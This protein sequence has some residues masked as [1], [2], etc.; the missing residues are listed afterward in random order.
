LNRIIRFSTFEFNY[1]EGGLPISTLFYQFIFLLTA[2]AHFNDSMKMKFSFVK[3]LIE[4]L[5][6]KKIV[7]K[8]NLLSKIKYYNLFYFKTLPCSNLKA[9]SKCLDGLV[10]FP[11]HSKTLWDL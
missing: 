1:F 11:F 3:T 6:I 5:K 4:V 9:L 7:N 2:E 8:N 10:L